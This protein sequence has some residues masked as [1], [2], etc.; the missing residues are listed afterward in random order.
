MKKIQNAAIKNG[1]AKPRI[2][3]PTGITVRLYPHQRTGIEW[4]HWREQ[5]KTCPGGIL[6]DEPGL[7]KT[8]T[9]GAFLLWVKVMGYLNGLSSHV[10]GRKR[11]R[12]AL[13]VVPKV[14]LH[15]WL[16]QLTETFMLP[17][18]LRVCIYH[19]SNADRRRVTD[20]MLAEYDLV[21]TTYMTL[22]IDVMGI[23]GKKQQMAPK[24]RLGRF[25]WTRL[26]LDE[27]HQTKSEKSKITQACRGIYS[28]IRWCVTGTPMDGKPNIWTLC[29]SRFLRAPK[30]TSVK[31]VLLMR[32]KKNI[33]TSVKHWHKVNVKLTT[34]ERKFYNQMVDIIENVEEKQEAN[35]RWVQQNRSKIRSQMR[36]ENPPPAGPLPRGWDASER[37][38]YFEWDDV[39]DG[40]CSVHPEY[41]LDSPQWAYLCEAFPIY[42]TL[43]KF[44]ADLRLRQIAVHT[45]IA[46]KAVSTGDAVDE[47]IKALDNEVRK[48]L[49]EKGISKEQL[50]RML[51]LDYE[52]SK[53]KA[54]MELLV[55]LVEAGEK[56]VVVSEWISLLKIVGRHLDARGISHE[57]MCGKTE[58]KE[59]YAIAQRFNNAESEPRV[60]LLASYSSG[61]GVD[62]PGGTRMFVMEPH[63]SAALQEQLFNRL[64]R[65]GQTMDVHCYMMVTIDT[66]EEDVVRERKSRERENRRHL[67]V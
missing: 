53:I 66:I 65:I 52:S 9:V 47:A 13:V 24:N 3:Q 42:H 15:Q 7:G 43:S 33:V 1:T 14:V 59:R 40:L 64:H 45:A 18:A 30:G 4:K 60:L 61:T 26:I 48:A 22:K 12:G 17:D 55:P 21:L 57:T 2:K 36:R 29:L 5:D 62:L 6:A 19:G 49:L 32:R 8:L 28:D 27:A 63:K 11:A 44:T 23:N 31:D 39:I 54:L 67:Q 58:A 16:K 25:H 20:Q 46:E 50:Q 51:E 56:C 35:R 10:N 37:R 34:T 38:R 41:H